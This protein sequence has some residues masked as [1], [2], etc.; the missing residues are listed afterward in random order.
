MIPGTTIL[1]PLNVYTDWMPRGGDNLIVQL[2]VIEIQGTS[3]HFYCEVFTKASEQTGNGSAIGSA[4]DFTTTGRK[5][6]AITSNGSGMKD[7]VRLRFQC[8]GTN[9]WV[10]FRVLDLI[11][12]D[13]PNA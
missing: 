11:W 5:E 1:Q 3:P 12:F 2:E 6:V 8:S 7:M 10:H 13:T 9:A 4:G